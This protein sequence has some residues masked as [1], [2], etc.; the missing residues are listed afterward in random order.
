MTNNPVIDEM[1]HQQELEARQS[2]FPVC[3]ECGR[4]LMNCDT[5]YRINYAYYCD[6]CVDVMTNDEMRESE[7]I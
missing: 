2:M 1:R 3:E 5:I 4:T 6:Y 7:G